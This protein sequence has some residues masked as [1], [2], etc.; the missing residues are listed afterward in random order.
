MRV[1]GV[2]ESTTVLQYVNDTIMFLRQSKEQS[3]KLHRYLLIF[4]L[5]S[6]LKINLN[7]S[8]I[9]I[10]GMDEEVVQEIAST[11]GCLIGSLPM[12]H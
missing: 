6:G 11:L 5:I 1:L 9:C 4:S 2:V 8:Y 12:K 7:K 3:V 10:V